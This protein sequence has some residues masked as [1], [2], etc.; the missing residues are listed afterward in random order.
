M[1]M[2]E[3]TMKVDIDTVRG[4]RERMKYI[5]LNNINITIN[6]G[7]AQATLTDGDE[8]VLD[9]VR[10]FMDEFIQADVSGGQ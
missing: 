6:N 5:G 1:N 7:Q 10:E 2:R 9:M 4:L 8:A 3:V